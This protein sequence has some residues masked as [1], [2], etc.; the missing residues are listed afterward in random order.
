M[1]RTLI[2]RR[3]EEVV[4]DLV[5]LNRHAMKEDFL[6]EKTGRENAKTGRENAPRR[7]DSLMITKTASRRRGLV[8]TPSPRP[9][10]LK[11]IFCSGADLERADAALLDEAA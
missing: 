1:A 8:K 3:R 9:G 5:L 6:C 11:F 2:T 10:K 7:L 4:D